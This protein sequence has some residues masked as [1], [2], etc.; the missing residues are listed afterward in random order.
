MKDILFPKPFVFQF[1]RDVYKFIFILGGISLIGFFV[2]LP[3]LK[4]NIDPEESENVNL[5]IFQKLMD[6][7]TIAIPPSL[8]ASM[9]FGMLFAL[10]RLRFQNIFCI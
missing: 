2:V 3:G 1:Q 4:A 8:I 6:S 7:I 5:E 9:N 10:A